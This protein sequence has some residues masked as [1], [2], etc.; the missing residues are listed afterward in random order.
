MK[1]S[2][3]MHMFYCFQQLIHLLFYPIFRKIVWSTFDGFVKV[4]LHEFEN[5]CKTASW[6]IVQNFNKLDYMW[7]WI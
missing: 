2:I 7:M 3:P 6:F 5:K 1:Y 4:H